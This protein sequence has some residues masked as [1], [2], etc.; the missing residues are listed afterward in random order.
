VLSTESTPETISP[1]L[2]SKQSS[3]EGPTETEIANMD[4]VDEEGYNGDG[5]TLTIDDDD[6]DSDEGLTMTRR[7]PTTSAPLPLARRGTNNSA[8]STDTAKKVTME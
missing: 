3:N 2:L 5:D 1:P 4:L 6:S 8:R 7:K